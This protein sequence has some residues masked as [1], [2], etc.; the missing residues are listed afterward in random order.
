MPALE[1]TCLQSLADLEQQEGLSME[2][3]GDGDPEGA[4]IVM[5]LGLSHMAMTA[6]Q[7]SNAMVLDRLDAE[8]AFVFEPD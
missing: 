4:A 6:K 1:M 7:L 3:L 8:L 5:R 2:V